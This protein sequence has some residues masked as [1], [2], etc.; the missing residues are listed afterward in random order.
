MK[1]KKV[2]K[3]YFKKAVIAKINTLDANNIKGG[4]RTLEDETAHN[5]HCQDY[6]C[7]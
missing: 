5:T 6:I 4:T 3:M 1:V 7:Y 2:K